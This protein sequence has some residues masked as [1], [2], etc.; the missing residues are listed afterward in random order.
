MLAKIRI[1]TI[2]WILSGFLAVVT[3]VSVATL[4]YTQNEFTKLENKWSVYASG[5]GEKQ[6]DLQN[7]NGFMGYGGMIHQFKNYVL[8]QDEKRIAKIRANSKLALDTISSLKNRGVT[9]QENAAL[10]TIAETIRKYENA[11]EVARKMVV[12]GKNPQEIDAVIKIDD[13][14]A[15]EAVKVMKKQ[16]LAEK[17]RHKAKMQEAVAR[18][19]SNGQ[20][21]MVISTALLL[22][23]LAF[24]I[25]FTSFHLGRP[26]QKLT[27]AISKLAAGDI[28]SELPMQG[29][30]D[31]M[32]EIIS[33]MMIFK[34]SARERIAREAEQQKQKALDLVEHQKAEQ[35]VQDK[36]V[37]AERQMVSD[38]FGKAIKAI[39]D[40][41]LSFRITT[42]VPPAYEGLKRDFNRALEQLAQTIEKI[43][44]ASEQILSGSQQL[45]N[46]ASDLARRTERQAATVEETAAA[47][48]ETT[49][50]MQTSTRRAEEAGQVVA[51]TKSHAE[52]SGEVVRKA[53]LAMGRI[54]QS[55]GEIANIIGVI[56]DI[57]FQTNL[58]AL[59]AGVEAARA[60]E[61][62]RGFAVVAQEVREL[63]QRSADAAK[64]IKKLIVSSGDSVKDGVHLVN[65]AG[66]ELESIV[67]EVKEIND[68][69]SAIVASASEQSLGLQEINQSVNSID[70]TTQQNAAAADDSTSASISLTEEVKRIDS[71]LKG[72]VTGKTGPRPQLASRS[73]NIKPH[74]S[75][76]RALTQKVAG[77]FAN[78]NSAAAHAFDD[79]SW[80]EF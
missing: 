60:G 24:T 36:A 28:D 47:L 12:L 50:A 80:E 3:A 8:R 65:E 49:V 41:N 45:S 52:S 76:A 5:T 27:R 10:D 75:P 56:D 44:D 33:A 19:T 48:E 55:S 29:R 64:E 62:G 22:L 59:N 11:A 31:E 21:S 57:A 66:G 14:P 1:S 26:M 35:Q 46:S 61:A 32:G 67:V 72:F 17:Q 25:W 71:M 18:V 39:S 77:S 54:E 53:I 2:G 74:P 30:G 4:L 78:T 68:H 69:V 13:R 9:K 20:I 79:E 58:L 7:L 42:D 63:A 40:R 70:Q 51:R 23:A 34:E 6:L 15:L 16:M 37:M 38:S 43:G 73:E